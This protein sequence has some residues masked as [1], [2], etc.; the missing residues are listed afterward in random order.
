MVF[1]YTVKDAS[2]RTISEGQIHIDDLS[3]I[4]QQRAFA[5]ALFILGNKLIETR[6]EAV[7][8]PASIELSVAMI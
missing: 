2:G 8:I 6:H 7:K 3:P 5:R 1:N 4:E